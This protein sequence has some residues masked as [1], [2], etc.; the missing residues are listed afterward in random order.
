MI[1]SRPTESTM[2]PF[3]PLPRLTIVF[4]LSL[5]L[6]VIGAGRVVGQTNVME[7]DPLRAR[8]LLIYDM[9]GGYVGLSNNMQ[10]GS[11][12]TA[13]NCEFTGGA[14]TSFAAGIVYEKLTRSR[15]VFGALLGFESRSIDARFIEIEGV[16]QR[17]PATSQE[18]IV[19]MSFRNIAEVSI[20]MVS[21]SPFVKVTFFDVAYLRAG[22]SLG[23][24]FSS[25][26]KHTKEL[27][28]DSVRFPNGEVASVAII[29]SNTRSVV[30][31]DG[32]LAEVNRLQISGLIG[33][34]M[35][36]KFSKKFFLGPVVQ[37]LVPF[38]SVSKRGT[39]FT[40]G[41]FQ[42]FVEGRFIF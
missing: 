32:P 27:I 38:T 13:C 18:Y 14:K 26:T 23:Y 36:F 24:I 1:V 8:T 22:P 2:R 28:D 15:I 30:L 37:Y 11:F 20:A 39:D 9:I 42:V 35:E 34:G 33:A 40:I 3:V 5:M 17:S 19:P 10:G 29:G 25:G 12:L 16:T 41:S 7:S 31:E 21:L 6:V 4:S